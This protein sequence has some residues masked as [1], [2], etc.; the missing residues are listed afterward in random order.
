MRFNVTKKKELNMRNMSVL[1]MLGLTS[2]L[3]LQA[4]AYAATPTPPAGVTIPP[5]I[6]PAAA[7]ARAALPTPPA[8]PTPAQARAAAAAARAALP[9]RPAAPPAPPAP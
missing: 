3:L 5:A 7:A 8:R 1:T 9:P 6:A 2:G 4:A